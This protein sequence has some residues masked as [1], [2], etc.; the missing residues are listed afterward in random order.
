ME[1]EHGPA[2][3][4]AAAARERDALHAAAVAAAAA[5]AATGGDGAATGAAVEGGGT[6]P[7]SAPAAGAARSAAGSHAPQLLEKELGALKAICERASQ[8][9]S[10]EGAAPVWSE[11]LIAA[12]AATSRAEA[13]LARL[14][15]PRARGAGGAPGSAAA[16]AVPEDAVPGNSLKR[17]RPAIEGGLSRKRAAP[18]RPELGAQLQPM[19]VARAPPGKRPGPRAKTPAQRTRAA[20]PAP[21]QPPAGAAAGGAGS[22]ARAAATG[23]A[24]APSKLSAP[25]ADAMAR[26]VA[27]QRAVQLAG[28]AAGHPPCP[29][30]L[31]I[32]PCFQCDN[33]HLTV[34]KE[35]A[36]MAPSVARQ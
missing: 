30:G 12:R 9:L 20:P 18:P 3:A 36:D 19:L 8:Q 31:T 34:G 15:G 21:R 7:Q 14:M 33:P 22:G 1:S 27:Q 13:A 28:G 11:A 24:P 32:R 26:P 10:A 23:S 5:E 6:A 17:L 4:R 25:S 35:A 2:A 16:F 29:H